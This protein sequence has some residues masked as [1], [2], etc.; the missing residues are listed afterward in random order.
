MNDI[1]HKFFHLQNSENCK[2]FLNMRDFCKNCEVGLEKKAF[3]I[4][5][6]CTSDDERLFLSDY[7]TRALFYGFLC[8]LQDML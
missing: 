2:D 1:F 6:K 4:E 8:S 5:V 7:K 3:I